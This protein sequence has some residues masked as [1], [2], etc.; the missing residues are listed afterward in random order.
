M[1]PAMERVETPETGGMLRLGGYENHR[2]QLQEERKREYN[3][4][5][6]KVCIL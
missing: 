4:M 3:Q 5:L 2:R 1:A 6:K